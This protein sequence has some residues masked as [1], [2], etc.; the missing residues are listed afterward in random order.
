MPRARAAAAR[1]VHHMGR[2]QARSP[3]SAMSTPGCRD[4][5]RGA[6]RHHHHRVGLRHDDQ[7]LRLH[8]P[9]GRSGLCREGGARLRRSPRTSPNIWRAGSNCPSRA[10]ASGAVAYHS[11]C[12]M[13]H[14]QQI[15]TSPRPCFRRPASRAR[16]AGGASLLR[17]GRHLQHPAAGDRGQLRE[18]KVGNIERPARCGRHRQYR[19]HDPGRL[20]DLST[21]RILGRY[22]RP[23]AYLVFGRMCATCRR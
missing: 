16:R 6:R 14:G 22:R 21:I 12:S 10:R 13:Q 18:R 20:H 15:K 4:R 1:S 8:V 23:S 3:R 5:R 19:L 11:A 7:G 9:R 2:E 17:L